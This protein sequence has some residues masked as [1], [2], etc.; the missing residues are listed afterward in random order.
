MILHIVKAKYKKKYMI[1]LRLND[2]SEGI[3][4]LKDELYGEMFEP[5]KNIKR[6]KSFR[7]DPELE[8]LVWKNGADLAPEFLRDRM[9]VL[10]S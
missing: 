8:T 10:N 1:W 4:D 6:F 2:G 3:V 5:L 9:Q 7:V